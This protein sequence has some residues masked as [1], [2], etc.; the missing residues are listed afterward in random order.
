MVKLSSTSSKSPSIMSAMTVNASVDSVKPTNRAS[1]SAIPVSKK[2][3][4]ASSKS[5]SVM[6]LLRLKP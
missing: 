6:V 3:I 2:A 1:K 5:D 4:V